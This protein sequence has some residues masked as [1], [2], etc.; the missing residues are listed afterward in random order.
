[1]NADDGACT[2]MCKDATCGED[3]ER[4]DDGDLVITAVRLDETAR[5]IGSTASRHHRALTALRGFALLAR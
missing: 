1:M 2:S 5:P 3:V 4:C